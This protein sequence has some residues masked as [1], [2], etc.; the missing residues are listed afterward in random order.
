MSIK[1]KLV[2]GHGSGNTLKINGEGELNVVVHPHPPKN[3]ENLAVP[4]RQ[5][6]TDDGTSSG[7]NDMRVNGATNSVDFYIKAETD[8]DI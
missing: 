1:T 5:Y 8:R 3:E 4:F 2:D 7:S 6:F